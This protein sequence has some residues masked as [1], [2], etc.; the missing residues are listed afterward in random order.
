MQDLKVSPLGNNRVIWYRITLHLSPSSPSLS[1]P[2]SL[3]DGPFIDM[4]N[5]PRAV[6]V[7]GMVTLECGANVD[8]NPAPTATWANPAGS[9]ITS[10]CGRFSVDVTGNRIRLEIRDAV[11]ED[12][13]VWTC[14]VT[15]EGTNV[16]V[17]GGGTAPTRFIGD[18]TN[19]VTLTV[20]GELQWHGRC[21]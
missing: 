1:L 9:N 7:D 3:P 21:I 20:V 18:F 13:G 5:E 10:D 6:A 12:M 14:F 15:V 11:V 16:T 17:P 8:S 4:V 19:S 2:P